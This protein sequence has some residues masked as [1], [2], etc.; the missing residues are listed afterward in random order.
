MK[1]RKGLFVITAALAVI[2]SACDAPANDTIDGDVSAPVVEEGYS[3]S[4]AG[5]PE[6]AAPS[7]D[8][9]PP[10][11]EVFKDASCDFEGWVGKPVDEAAIKEL[12]RPY[13][14]LKPGDMMTMDHNPDRINVE[15]DNGAVTRVFC[16]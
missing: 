5:M 2:L 3:G 1:A 7:S 16:G 10:A 4:N 9:P 13:R 8:L 6:D 14:I 15:H 12:G 11:R